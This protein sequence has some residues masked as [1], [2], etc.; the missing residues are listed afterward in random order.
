LNDQLRREWYSRA[1]VQQNIVPCI[2]GREVAF[3]LPNSLRGESGNYPVRCIKAH[4][5]SY[6][7]NNMR[8]FDFF[9]RKYNLY[10][11]IY[12]VRNMPMFSYLP[13]RRREQQQEFFKNY[14]NYVEGLDFVM[15]F[16]G[17]K[18]LPVEQRVDAAR[19]AT[20]QVC[21]ILDEYEVPYCVI[22][23]GSKGF[24]VEVRDFPPTREWKKRINDFSMIAKLLILHANGESSLNADDN[25]TLRDLRERL[26]VFSFDSRDQA[27]KEKLDRLDHET[28]LYLYLKYRHNFDSTIYNATRIWKVP[29]SYD[30]STDMIAYPL[31]AE[32]LLNFD[33][34]KYH[35]ENML[36]RNHWNTGLKKRKGIIQNFWKLAESLGVQS[37]RA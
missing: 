15:D 10:H 1:D 31:S 12:L 37:C 22:F 27:L 13:Q 9:N 33:I 16:D 24:H 29:Y 30:V 23:S 17:D 28:L 2:C 3:M 25:A 8:A 5:S 19:I 32:E 18:N 4:C 14:D 7:L 34:R 36:K 21:R 11:S 35:V 26:I 6:L 20:M